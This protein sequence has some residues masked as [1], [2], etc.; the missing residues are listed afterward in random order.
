MYLKKIF[1]FVLGVA[2]LAGA[3]YMGLWYAGARAQAN[4]MSSLLQ[5]KQSTAEQK[6]PSAI[7]RMISFAKTDAPVW[8][9]AELLG[10]TFACMGEHGASVVWY[11][12][13]QSLLIEEEGRPNAL[14]AS[15]IANP[16]CTA[17]NPP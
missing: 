15:K 7:L 14:I 9:E 1:F 6:Y 12:A 11:N 2:A 8:M 4:F 16:H 10:D 13:A 17:K 3:F 5:A